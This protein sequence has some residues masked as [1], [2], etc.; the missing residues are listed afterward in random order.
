MFTHGFIKAAVTQKSDDLEKVSSLAGLGLSSGIGALGGGEPDEEG[1][2]KNRHV[3]ALRGAG[4]Y[5]GAGLGGYAGARSALK[6]SKRPRRRPGSRRVIH[7]GGPPG[8]VTRLKG[9]AGARQLALRTLLGLGAGGLAGYH[10]MKHL[11]PKYDYEK[12]QH[13]HHKD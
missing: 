4:A 6:V 11:G 12:K 10:A 1:E 8:L 9:V 13:A 2:I 7:P 3:G 5:L